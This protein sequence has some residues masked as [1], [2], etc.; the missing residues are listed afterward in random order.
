M[1]NKV[2]AFIR[3]QQLLNPEGLHLVAVS[4]G[5]DSVALLL[6]L[7][8]LGYRVEAVHCNFKLRGEESLRD[9]DFVRQLCKDNNIKFHVTHFETEEY[10][11]IHQLSIEMAARELRYHYFEQLRMDIGAESVCVAHHANDAA[12]TLLMNLMRGTGIRGLTG[13]RPRNG[14]IVRPFLC[15]TRQEIESW[16]HDINQPFITDSSNLV[17]D[18]LRNKIRLN[19]LPLMQQ[20]MPGSLEGIIKTA[21][22]MAE[23]EKV[24]NQAVKQQLATIVTDN[25]V[26]IPQLLQQPSPEYLLH[27]WL[28]PLGFN[29]SQVQQI[30][31]HL[32]STSGREYLS[33]THSLVIDRETIV[34]EHIQEPMKP[35][36][37]PETG[38]YR[39]T[40]SC[41]FRFIMTD[42]VSLSKSPSCATLDAFNIHFPLF[43]RPVQSGDRFTPYG[44]NGSRLV[45]DLLTDLKF[46]LH[47]KRRQL[48]VTDAD[49]HILWLVGL[50]IDDHYRITQ[51][52]TRMLV[53]SEN[54]N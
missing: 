31:V 49:N 54:K 39:Y 19:I 51:Q 26:S 18:V 28:S 52:T 44:M 12:E 1:L 30:S 2:S 46:T 47:Q 42:D 37:I 5:A 40:P 14:H 8:Q 3:Q 48:V 35:M 53:I 15:V 36:K 32:G 34:V 9:E 41:T 6:A 11:T 25:A 20:S 50:R 17:D 13:I 21:A 22:H 23:A 27:E 16:L 33:P 45:S 29:A 10:A 4:G 7:R 38:C 43:V 24:F